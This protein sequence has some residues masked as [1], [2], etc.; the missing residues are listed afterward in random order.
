MSSTFQLKTGD[1]YMVKFHPG[2]GG[3]FRKYRPAVIVS[4]YVNKI[5]PDLVMVAPLST[6]IN[7]LREYE[8]VVRNPGLRSP[9]AVVCWYLRTIDRDRLIEK[10]GTLSKKDIDLTLKTITQL[11]NRKK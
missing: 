8:F 4:D 10:I 1:L 6:K 11:I 5:H 3:E 7:P 9:S 2:Y